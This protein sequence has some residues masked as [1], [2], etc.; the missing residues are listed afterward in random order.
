[1]DPQRSQ[2]HFCGPPCACPAW[3]N[4]CD[5]NP[6]SAYD[7][8]AIQRFQEAVSPLRATVHH[9]PTTLPETANNSCTATPDQVRCGKDGFTISLLNSSSCTGQVYEACLLDDDRVL[10]CFT[11]DNFRPDDI[12]TPPL[13]FRLS[14]H[15]LRVRTWTHGQ[16]LWELTTDC[17]GHSFCALG[18]CIFC[19]DIWNNKS[20]LMERILQTTF[21]ICA[22]LLIG[23]ALKL[24]IAYLLHRCHRCARRRGWTLKRHATTF[25]AAQATVSWKRL[26][27]SR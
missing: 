26:P 3:A 9:R 15:T 27:F 22:T 1:M 13:E 21:G 10:S 11:S 6:P 7:T 23:L 17:D 18:T 24:V 5:L 8:N 2:R 12:I 20:C 25:S 19:W 4:D 16:L 14:T